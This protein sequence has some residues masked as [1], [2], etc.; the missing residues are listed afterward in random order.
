MKF[1]TFFLF[2]SIMVYSQE[3][4]EESTMLPLFLSTMNLESTDITKIDFNTISKRIQ[5][6]AAFQYNRDNRN[7]RNFVVL[8]KDLNKVYKLSSFSSA[9]NLKT[10]L[11]EV[12]FTGNFFNPNETHFSVLNKEHK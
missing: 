9:I 3:N 8:S 12:M 7:N 5:T 11:E 4:R 6:S 1:L 10:E 2:A